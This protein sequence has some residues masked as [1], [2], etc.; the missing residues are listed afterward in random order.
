MLASGLFVALLLPVETNVTNDGLGQRLA[1]ELGARIPPRRADAVAGTAFGARIRGLKGRDRDDVIVGEL[2]AGNLPAFL[3]ELERVY[4]SA[5]DSKGTLHQAVVFVSPDYLAVG[6]NEDFLRVPLGFDAAVAIAHEFGF[7]LPTRKIVD[8]IYQQSAL[9]LAP[10]PMTPGPQMTSTDYFVEHN[11]IIEGQRQ[12]QPLGQLVSGHKKDLV[13]TKRLLSK[14]G[15]VAIY[16]WHR[17]S[18]RPIQPLSTVHVARY[19]DYSHGVRLVS[20]HRPPR[21]PPLLHLRDSREPRARPHPDL[22]GRRFAAPSASWQLR[23]QATTGSDVDSIV[24][25]QRKPRW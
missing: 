5:R 6:S 1:V 8:T 2:S 4:L 13:L 24:L 7:V 15:R 19:A 3:R 20:T 16:G 17:R 10:E 12:G 18:G 23:T 21:R 14:R 11:R 9:R 25:Q 22:R